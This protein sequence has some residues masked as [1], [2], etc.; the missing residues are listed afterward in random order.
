[1]YAYQKPEGLVLNIK[2]IT[3]AMKSEVIGE[4]GNFLKVK[5]NA[6]PEKGKANAELIKLLS[7]DFDISQGKIE[8]LR[9]LTSNK[10]VV[11]LRGYRL[12]K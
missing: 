11:L 5:L 2:V 12:E 6:I 4:S 1:M 7:I 9:G 10:K 8:I 3:K